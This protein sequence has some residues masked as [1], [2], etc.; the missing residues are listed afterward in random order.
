MIGLGNFTAFAVL[1][2]FGNILSLASTGF[3][4]GPL[5]Q[6]KSMFDPTRVITTIVFLA[7]MIMTLL[8]ALL[9]RI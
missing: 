8:S 1:Y 7:A 6:L 3:L 4:V 2:T 9:V 5:R